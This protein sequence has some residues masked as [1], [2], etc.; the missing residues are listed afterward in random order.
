MKIKHGKTT[1]GGVIHCV[2]WLMVGHVMYCNNAGLPK[3]HAL[4]NEALIGCI[5]IG[6]GVLWHAVQSAD[7]PKE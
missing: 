6:I 5:I 2:G 7:K 3:T 1:L 4:A